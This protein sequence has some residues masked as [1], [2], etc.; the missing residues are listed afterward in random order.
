MVEG[1]G[2]KRPIAPNESPQSSAT[3][4]QRKDGVELT[5]SLTDD[6]VST[7]ED[8]EWSTILF[9]NEREVEP[10][11]QSGAFLDPSR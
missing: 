1:V 10:G 8:G 11:R 2:N 6:T 3:C 9:K 7:V 4:V 5:G